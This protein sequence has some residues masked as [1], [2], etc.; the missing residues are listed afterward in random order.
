LTFF[1]A[2]GLKVEGKA[3]KIGEPK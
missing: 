1:V 3:P 2:L